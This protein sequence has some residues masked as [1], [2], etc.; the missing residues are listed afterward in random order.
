MNRVLLPSL[1]D[2]ALNDSE[3]THAKDSE[4]V[5][6]Q[7]WHFSMNILLYKFDVG[8]SVLRLRQRSEDTTSLLPLGASQPHS[9]GHEYMTKVALL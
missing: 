4:R 2:R 3:F 9:A 6:T 1:E 8:C 7:S 5:C